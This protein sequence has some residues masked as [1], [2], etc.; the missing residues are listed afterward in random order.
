MTPRNRREFM[1]DVGRGM[2]V[3][4]IGTST[5]GMMGFSTAFAEEGDESLSFG[6]L[7]GLVDLMQST[8][9]DKLQ[10]LL[11]KKLQAGE[12]DLPQLVSAAALANAET[13]G[14]QDY[15]G[16]HTAMAMLPALEIARVVPR[17][18]QPLPV[19]KVL[20]RNSGQIQEKGGASRK[21]LRPLT[22]QSDSAGQTGEQLRQ[23]V[24]DVNM[25][26]AEQI[27]AGM[28]Q[29]ST[30]DAYNH[31][32][33]IVQDD[34]NVHRFVLA[35][36]SYRL[37]NL[38]GA[39]HAHTIL[40]QCVRFCVEHER[41]RTSR[42]RP[43]S[44]IRTV[45]PA[46]FDEYGLESVSLGKKDPG[47][48][49]VAA[50]SETIYGSPPEQAAEAVAAAFAEGVDP[51]VIG[52]AISLAAN[53]LVL[54]QGTEKWRTHGDS[55]GVHSSDAA[56]AW[57]NM[58]RVT[59]DRNAIAG[60]IVGAFHTARFNEFSGAPY[61]T[62]DHLAQIKTTDPQKLLLEAADAVEQND[63]ARAAAA[64]HLYGA[65]GGS[66]GAVFDVMAKYTVSEDGRLH[67]EKYFQTVREEYDTTREAF[68][69]RQMVGLARV[70]AS[71]YGYDREDNHGHRAPG[72]ADACRLLGVEA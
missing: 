39:E 48:E 9:P 70:T 31:L 17:E 36:R 57:R 71:A 66:P 11:V 10:P 43:P 23:A 63:Q 6:Q 13:F 32:Q 60:L 46:L 58:A 40:R 15:V 30:E 34:I 27:F 12:T 68:R 37:V 16:F 53:L 54:R 64:V 51:E 52:E 67:G 26:G 69:W 56:N 5:A 19:L 21:T 49:W 62:E 7:D 18:R 72:Y 38:L 24:R 45:L 8:P 3:A 65:Q 59:N 28:M 29:G 61:P 41:N 47:D 1:G 50:L 14:G 25:N 20:Y 33:S 55:A 42:N 4:G 44:P 2:L 22:A 35:H